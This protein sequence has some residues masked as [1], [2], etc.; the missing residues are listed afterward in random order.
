MPFV[1]YQGGGEDMTVR[2]PLSPCQ[3]RPI[4]VTLGLP[5]IC[6]SANGTRGH[7]R[8]Y[9]ISHNRMKVFTH[10]SLQDTI[11]IWNSLLPQVA[12]GSATLNTFKNL[13]KVTL[14]NCTLNTVFRLILAALYINCKS[15]LYT[16]AFMRYEETPHMCHVPIQKKKK[17]KFHIPLSI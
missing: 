9:L 5:T 14:R 8:K 10:S 1:P 11:R 6:C 15:L 4:M 17:K 2:C 12:V 16:C 13:L 7:H 3:R